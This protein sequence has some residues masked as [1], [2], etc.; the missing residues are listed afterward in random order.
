MTA[1]PR[2]ARRP[3]FLAAAVAFSVT[4][5][6]FVTAIPAHAAVTATNPSVTE[7]GDAG[8]T[9]LDFVVTRASSDP[10]TID[11]QTLPETATEGR[12]YLPLTEGTLVFADGELEKHVRVDVLG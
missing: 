3:R 4:A 2:R 10:M 1:L 5:L 11:Y 8:L 7:P 9:R 12:D 6:Q